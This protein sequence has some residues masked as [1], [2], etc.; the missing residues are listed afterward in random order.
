M[1]KYPLWIT[2]AVFTC[3]SLVGGLLV[4]LVPD[5]HGYPLPETVTEIEMWPI[6]LCRWLPT[7]LD[8]DLVMAARRKELEELGQGGDGQVAKRANGPAPVP[9]SY[10]RDYNNPAFTPDPSG[11]TSSVNVVG[12]S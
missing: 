2:G 5:P 12:N 4:L 1:V 8:E 11:F 7:E 6:N 3:L 9:A 10:G